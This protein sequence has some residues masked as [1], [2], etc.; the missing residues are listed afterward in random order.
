MPL[1][2]V[3]THVSLHSSHRYM[4]RNFSLSLNFLHINGLLCPK[5][6]M[7][8]CNTILKAYKMYRYLCKADTCTT[9]GHDFVVA[10]RAIFLLCFKRHVV[11][12]IS[13]LFAGNLWNGEQCPGSPLYNHAPT[14]TPLSRSS[15]ELFVN[16]P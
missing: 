11:S 12:D 9:F 8:E 6:S 7:P 10:I 15:R 2:K 16:C 1:R 13:C 3:S 5:I 4:G 14:R